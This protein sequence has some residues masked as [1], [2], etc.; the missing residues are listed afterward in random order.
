MEGREGGG[1]EGGKSLI[2]NGRTIKTQN[3]ISNG[4][5]LKKSL[6]L[7][8]RT[9]KTQ[10]PISNGRTLN[11]KGIGRNE[12][13]QKLGE[14]IN[15]TQSPISNGRTLNRGVKQNT[16]CEDIRTRSQIPSSK[17]L[18]RSLILNCRTI[19]TQSPISNG[20]TLNQEGIGRSEEEQKQGGAVSKC[21]ISNGRTI[22]TQARYQMVGL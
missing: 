19:K 16:N 14:A 20:R 13:R 5:E 10:R 6:T 4:R 21:P 17:D 22:K 7:N 9:I 8:H 3:P 15:K 12:D 11:Q 1:K 18:D 2:L